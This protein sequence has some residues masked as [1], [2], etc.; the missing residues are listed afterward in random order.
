MRTQLI[1]LAKQV[2]YVNYHYVTAYLFLLS[3]HCK[4]KNLI[5][6][7]LNSAYKRFVYNQ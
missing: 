1:E 7:N 6:S 5:K 4:I 3:L 2:M